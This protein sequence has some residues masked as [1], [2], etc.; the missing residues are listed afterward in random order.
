MPLTLSTQHL[1]SNRLSE[2]QE[3]TTSMSVNGGKDGHLWQMPMDY[4]PA[5]RRNDVV[6]PAMNRRSLED[7]TL[8]ERRQAQQAMDSVIP[9]M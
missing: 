4:H 1:E 8:G 9:L 3:S 5:S 7:I 6:T 2:T